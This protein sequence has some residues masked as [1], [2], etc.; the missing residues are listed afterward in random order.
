MIRGPVYAILRATGAQR[1]SG[2]EGGGE[3]KAETA[4]EEWWTKKPCL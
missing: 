2:I 1:V 3:V 4:F